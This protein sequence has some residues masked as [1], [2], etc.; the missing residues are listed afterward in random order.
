[1]DVMAGITRHMD[2]A[3]LS[4]WHLTA[5]QR[6]CWHT[7]KALPAMARAFWVASTLPA[8]LT[9][10]HVFGNPRFFRKVL[11]ELGLDRW[12]RSPRTAALW[13]QPLT[14][15]TTTTWL[16]PSG[17]TTPWLD[18]AT[19]VQQVRLGGA[20]QSGTGACLSHKFVRGR[21]GV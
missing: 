5:D 18:R 9:R 17:D 3:H 6:R 20:V 7:Q 15:T 21:H 2:L 8:V 11:Q 4:C 19:T 1:M 12:S 14:A 13:L 16:A 10:R